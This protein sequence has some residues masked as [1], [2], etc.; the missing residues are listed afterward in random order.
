MNEIIEHD[1]DFILFLYWMIVMKQYVKTDEDY[2]RLYK[3][4]QRDKKIDKIN[5]NNS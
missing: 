1:N 2:S 3:V 4:F 5:E